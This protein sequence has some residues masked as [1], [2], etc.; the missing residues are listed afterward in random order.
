M[1]FGCLISLLGIC[2]LQAVNDSS[3][4]DISV[5]DSIRASA[6]YGNREASLIPGTRIDIEKIPKDQTV[7]DVLRSQSGIQVKDY[8]GVG[9]LKTVNVRSLG[10]EHNGVFINGIA[11]EN[12]QNM[13]VDIGRFSL[14]EL[15]EITIYNA[16]GCAR[17]QSAKEYASANSICL[18]YRTPELKGRFGGKARIRGGSFGTLSPAVTL[19]A[20]LGKNVV[21]TLSTEYTR[22]NGKYRFHNSRYYR[23]NGEVKGYDTTMIR[24]N[25]DISAIRVEG[26]LSGTGNGRSSWNSHVYYYDSER[27][28]PGPV[29]RSATVLP[30]Y[31]D[32][33]A[34]RNFF[35]QGAWKHPLGGNFH[36][37]IKIQGKY[38]WDYT[39]YR[40]DPDKNPQAM[41]TDVTY[42][43]HN[44][45]LS[46][47]WAMSPFEWWSINLASDVQFNTLDGTSKY[48]A[49]PQRL[50]LWE[51]LALDFNWNI[52]RI[53]ANANWCFTADWFDNTGSGAFAREDR[54]CSNFSPALLFQI[55]PLE[56]GSSSLTINGFVKRSYRMPSFNDLYY[57]LVG[58]SSL[59]S[60]KAFQSDLG[61]TYIYRFSTV[62]SLTL[63][64]EC[65]YNYLK[66]KI[67][68][69]PTSS[70]FRWTMLNIGKVRTIGN[71]TSASLAYAGNNG[72]G[73]ELNA[74]YTYQNSTD[75]SDPDHASYGGQIPYIPLHT[76][77]VSA[78]ASYKGWMAAVTFTA[79][80]ERWSSSA[81]L[82]DYHID[83]WCTCDLS[84]SKTVLQRI[85]L[86]GSLRNIT[87]SQYE[88]VKGYPM[89]GINF[90]LGVSYEF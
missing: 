85:T 7:A 88:V 22:S 54:T 62:L 66:D 32:R 12:A 50:S 23:I 8:G 83:P 84:L 46:A 19:N 56:N 1:F 68:A 53:S 17:L 26:R 3:G 37:E 43:Q 51:A 38:A 49:Q 36:Q 73:I 63:K 79:M 45:Y 52:V 55:S 48:F 40:T 72:L 9:G 77:A 71:E 18:S 65:Y 24:Q 14:D 2:S 70:M 15:A 35:V 31:G 61:L 87:D 20:R 5:R 60:E 59:D 13:Q 39:R 29:V 57:T 30:G 82:F 6:I 89:P 90:M 41:P 10:S 80:S 4:V 44:A 28:L 16:N 69:I 81:N 25:G 42:R 34:D 64:T 78:N 67:V 86:S 33:Q 74:R 58:N 47:S 11:V 76:V 27:G 21:G 75:R